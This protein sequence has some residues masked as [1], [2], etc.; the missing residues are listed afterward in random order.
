MWVSGEEHFRLN[1]KPL[2]SKYACCVWP[3]TPR[4]S[5]WLEQRGGERRAYEHSDVTGQLILLASSIY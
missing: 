3:G 1:A 2:R 5:K 4:R